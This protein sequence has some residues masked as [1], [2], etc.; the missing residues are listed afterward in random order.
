MSRVGVFASPDEAREFKQLLL[1]LRAAGYALNAGAKRPAVFEEPQEF[2]VAN[3]TGEAVPPFAVMQC[4]S[5]QD[6]AIEIQKP[7]DRYGVNGPYL[8]NSGKEIAIDG[9][10]V[11][12]NIGPITVHTDGTSEAELD[13]FSPEV[14]EWFAIRNP[15]GNLIYLGNSSLRDSGDCV[16]ALVDTFPQVIHAKTGASGIA[17]ASGSTTR[18]M[19]KADCNLYESSSTGGLTD[20]DLEIELYNFAATAVQSSTFVLAS[21]NDKGL[22]IVVAEDCA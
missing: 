11:G 21:R 20:T 16:F 5:Y 9:R 19:S 18:A 1:Q 7:A 6:G 12:R 22:W 17:A 8:I 10:G 14:H 15:A 2:I 4:I 13:R 3:T